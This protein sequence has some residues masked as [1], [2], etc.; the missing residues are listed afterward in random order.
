MVTDIDGWFAEPDH[1]PD[2]P[3]MEGGRHQPRMP[4]MK[5]AATA[6][7]ASPPAGLPAGAARE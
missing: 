4:K 7:P 2:L 3:F 6:S 1:F 5:R